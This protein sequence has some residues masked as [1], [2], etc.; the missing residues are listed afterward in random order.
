MASVR[1]GYRNT[2]C[3]KGSVT[4]PFTDSTGSFTTDKA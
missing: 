2:A 1:R 4:A 3:R